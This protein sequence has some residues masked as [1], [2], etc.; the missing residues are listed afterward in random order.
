VSFSRRP[1]A[2]TPQAWTAVPALAAACLVALALLA[3]APPA[4]A[5]SGGLASS[6]SGETVETPSIP[7]STTETEV[8]GVTAPSGVTIP[9]PTVPGALATMAGEKAI[10][11]GSAPTAVKRVIAAANHIRTTPYIW[12]GGHLRWADKGYDCSGAVSYALH[13]GGLIEAPLVS[14]SFATWGE[15]GPGRWITI[16]A[17]KAHVYMVVAGLRWDTGGDPTGVTGPRWHAEPPYPQGFVVRHPV[18]Y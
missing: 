4:H 14:G 6:Y 2:T 12:G 10:A 18:G 16:Y 17:N 15:P 11:P 8:P 9:A 1:H 3:A 13:G 7:A 5:E